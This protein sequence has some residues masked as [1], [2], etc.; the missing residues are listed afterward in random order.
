VA[1]R[2]KALWKPCSIDPHCRVQFLS[3]RCQRGSHMSI[4]HYH[5]YALCS[6]RRIQR[7]RISWPQVL[8]TLFSHHQYY[9]NAFLHFRSYFYSTHNI[10][11]S[12]FHIP[13][14]TFHIPHYNFL[15]SEFRYIPITSI[16]NPIFIPLRF[17]PH[18]SHQRFGAPFCWCIPLHTYS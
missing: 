2:S 6:L 1:E 10:P 15:T 12:T 8:R 3:K 16:F 4:A 9:F 17:L 7:N 13:Y 14:S 11:H 5:I 18:M